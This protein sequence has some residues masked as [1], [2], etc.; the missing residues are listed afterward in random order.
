MI[1]GGMASGRLD[2]IITGIF[3]GNRRFTGKP[4]GSSCGYRLNV[5]LTVSPDLYRCSSACGYVPCNS[6]TARRV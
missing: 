4:P 1:S 3:T 2:A 5:F 6:S